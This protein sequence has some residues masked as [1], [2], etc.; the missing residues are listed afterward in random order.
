MTPD[1]GVRPEPLPSTGIEQKDPVRKHKYVDEVVRRHV[2]AWNWFR[3]ASPT[4]AAQRQG[5]SGILVSRGVP[6]RRHGGVFLDW[7][8]AACKVI[9]PDIPFPACWKISRSVLHH[10]TSSFADRPYALRF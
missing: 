8:M 10:A 4:A 2:R 1:E 5:Q 9:H 7:E 6:E 3:C